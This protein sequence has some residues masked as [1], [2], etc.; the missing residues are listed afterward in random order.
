MSSLKYIFYIFALIYLTE[1]SGDV[2]LKLFSSIEV[3]III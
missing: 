1:V 2:Y 3:W